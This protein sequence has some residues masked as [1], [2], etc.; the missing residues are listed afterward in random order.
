VGNLPLSFYPSITFTS[1][2]STP[3]TLPLAGAQQG[4]APLTQHEAG[5]KVGTQPQTNN[6][7]R[8]D[9][10]GGAALLD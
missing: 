7:G 3:S 4:S 9:V 6:S 5:N 1:R 8:E 10:V 2:P